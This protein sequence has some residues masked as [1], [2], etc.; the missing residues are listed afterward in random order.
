MNVARVITSESESHINISAPA[1]TQSTL[2]DAA[3]GLATLLTPAAALDHTQR[4]HIREV[5]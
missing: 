3:A 2:G 1:D 5:T 4:V